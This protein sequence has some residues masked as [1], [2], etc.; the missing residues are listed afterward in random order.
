MSSAIRAIAKLIAPLRVCGLAL[1]ALPLV[2]IPALGASSAWFEYEHGA[3]R[4]ISGQASAGNGETLEFGLQFRMKPG[5]KVYWRSP[6]D[7]GF[8]PQVSWVGSTN[9]AGATMTWPAPKRFSV[10][11]LETLGY[12]DEVVFPIEASVFEAGKAVDIRARLRFLTC[13]DICVPYETSFNLSLPPGP[14]LNTADSGTISTWRGKVPSVVM[15]AEPAAL[16]IERAEVAGSGADQALIIR[17]TGTDALKNPDL[18]VEGPDD[19]GFKKP[20][21]QIASV[22]NEALMRIGVQPPKRPDARLAGETVTLT[23]VDGDRAIERKLKL[24]RAASTAAGFPASAGGQSAGD[25]SGYGFLAILGLALLGGLILN[26]MPCVL[27]VLSI[28][29]LTVV[30]H[31]GEAPSRIR[32]GFLASA[33]GIL[34]C[35]MILATIAA[36]LQSAGL[37]AGWGIQFQQPAFLAFM[38]AVITLFACNM[39]GLFEIRLPG[40]VADAAANTGSKSSGLGGHFL[41]GAFATLLATPC[42]APFLGTAV[43]FALSRGPLEIYSVFL[44]LGVGLAAPWIVVAAFPVLANRLPKPGQWMIALK[45]IL[46]IALVGTALWLLSVLWFQIGSAATGIIASLMIAIAFTVW[47]YRHLGE[48]AR[49]ATW[50]V[51]GLLTAISMVGAHS[52]VGAGGGNTVVAADK[53]WRKFDLAVIGAEVAKGNTVFVDVTADW[54]LTCQVN[55]SLVLTRGRVAEILGAG[56]IVAM[57]ADWTKPD[58]VISAYLKGFGRYGIPFNVV[59]GPSM[60]GGVPLPEILTESSVLAAFVKAGGKAALAVR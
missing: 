57:K 38:I 10:L 9:F 15:S 8:P 1:A 16:T 50:I 36:G 18:F 51:V 32:A 6:G 35:F 52:L 45:R 17:I 19:Y 40:A 60:P 34:A 13:D 2:A 53:T 37:A 54:C 14:D 48:R 26:L 46:S 23:L 56:R 43:G 12:K 33:A 28:K 30:S 24:E 20:V 42:T 47:Q 3:V 58:P 44:A 31:G 59:Y 29:L 7:A 49:F 55:K 4:L 22:G 41:T 11:G 5:W 27:P 25:G 21:V 39:W